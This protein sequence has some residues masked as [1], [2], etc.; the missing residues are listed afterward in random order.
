MNAR[1]A[2]ACF[3]LSAAAAL[4]AD[5]PYGVLD[6]VL[7]A[8]YSRLAQQL[9]FRDI[10]A[11]LAGSRPGK[12][13]LGRRGYGCMRR[14][15]P[16]ADIG[17]VSHEEKLDGI[18]TREIRLHFLNGRLQQFSVTAELQH[19]ESVVGYLR[20]RH[21]EPRQVAPA[22]P[23]AAPSLQWQNESGRIIV[24]RGKDLVFV[25]LELVS[26]A[27]AVQRKREGTSV[28]CT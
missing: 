24:Y 23:D 7:G 2:I 18:E 22:A 16:Y 3:C 14:D 11:S 10:N 8:S 21:G 20:A 1:F 19:L 5:E 26:Y 13:D 28:E 17:C 27:G 9:D 6:I 4:A 25:N 15:D 12:P